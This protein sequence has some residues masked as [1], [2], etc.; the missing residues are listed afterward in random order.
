[1]D[2]CAGPVLGGILV[3]AAVNHQVFSAFSLLFAYGFGAALPLIALSYGGRKFSQR[4]LGLRRHS[5]ILQKVGGIIVILTA[6]FILLGWD[7]KIQLWLAPF[8]PTL[9]I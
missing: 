3:L 7:I 6:L 9:P 8:F 4:L 2:T 5:G 1:M